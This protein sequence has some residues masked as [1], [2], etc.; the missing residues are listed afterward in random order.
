MRPVEIKIHESKAYKQ[1]DGVERIGYHIEDELIGVSWRW[2]EN[3]DRGREPLPEE[4]RKWCV[5]WLVR[6]EEAREGRNAF[7]AQFL[8]DARLGE[9]YA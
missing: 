1:I 2:C 3:D 5:E 4:T 9:Y 7:A 8:D 6:G